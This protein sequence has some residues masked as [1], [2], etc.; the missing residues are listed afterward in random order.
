M[1]GSLILVSTVL[2]ITPGRHPTACKVAVYTVPVA[3][4]LGDLAMTSAVLKTESTSGATSLS[5]RLILLAV[6]LRLHCS[7]HL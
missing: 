4:P 5:L 3:L 6:L 7:C 2:V 1:H